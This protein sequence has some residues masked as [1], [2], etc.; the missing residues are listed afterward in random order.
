MRGP[1]T[2]IGDKGKNLVAIKLESVGGGKIVSNENNL[3]RNIL[4]GMFMIAD[5]ITQDPL[6]DKLHVTAAF[7]EIFVLNR[8]K[9]VADT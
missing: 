4:E 9:E 5:E 6:S 1:A 7:A 2:G 3:L 8:R